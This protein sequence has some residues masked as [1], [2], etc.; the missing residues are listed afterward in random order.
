MNCDHLIIKGTL[1]NTQIFDLCEYPFIIENQKK[2]NKNNKYEIFGLKNKED[3]SLIEFEYY[4]Y[5]DWCPK[6]KNNV[7][8][9][10]NV[11]IS[12]VRLLYV[13]EQFLRILNYFTT[14]FLGVF[15][16]SN[17]LKEDTIILNN[18]D[19]NEQNKLIETELNN[20]RFLNMNIELNEPLMILKP[21]HYFEEEFYINFGKVNINCNYNLVEGKYFKNLKS[22]RWLTTYQIKLK[23]FL[24]DTKDNL[25]IQG[26]LNQSA[27]FPLSS[28]TCKEINQAL[29]KKNPRKSVLTPSC[30]CA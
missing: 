22:K 24:I 11:K 28:T 15:S 27:L 9:I 8:G 1:G 12:S 18:L 16:N 29:K 10:A 17:N 4:S 20:F 7:G 30:F 25:H 14:Q 23:N 19:I 13:Q 2:F 5:N 3:K 21:R 26:A 6:L